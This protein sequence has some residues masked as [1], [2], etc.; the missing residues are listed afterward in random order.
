MLGFAKIIRKRLEDRIFPLVQSDD[1]KVQQ[2]IAQVQDNL[3]V[4]VSEGERLT[5]L[6]DDVLD[7]AKI[8]A[9]KLEWHMEAVAAERHHRPRHRRHRVAVR[10]EGAQG[11]SSTWPPA[12]PR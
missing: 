7:L 4:V 11:W 12:C 3:K 2:T 8:E 1:K 5:K 10:S 6:I 9:G